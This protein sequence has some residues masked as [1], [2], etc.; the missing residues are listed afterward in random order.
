MS[1]APPFFFEDKNIGQNADPVQVER[2]Q[3]TD[4]TFYFRAF[5][6]VTHIFGAPI[7]GGW[8]EGFGTTEAQARE[9]LEEEE[10]KFNDTLWC[11]DAF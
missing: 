4:G 7:Q 5:T 6:R 9:R 3:N 8:L 10:K 2:K 1:D 11:D